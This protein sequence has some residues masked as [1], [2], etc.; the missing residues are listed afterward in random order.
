MKL[1][2]IFTF[3]LALALLVS[4]LGFCVQAYIKGDLDSSGE[5][6]A[7]DAIY[8]LYNV[9]FGDSSYPLSQ[10]CDYDGSGTKDA[11]DAIWLLYNVFFGDEGYPLVENPTTAQEKKYYAPV[12]ENAK[13]EYSSMRSTLRTW[14]EDKLDKGELFSLKLDGA[15]MLSSMKEKISYT[16]NSNGHTA[17]KAVYTSDAHGLKVTLEG[18]LYKDY[19]TVDYVVYVENTSDK[20]SGLISDF[21]ALDSD[22]AL[23]KNGSYTLNTLTGSTA[24]K[25]DFDPVTKTLSSSYQTFA[26]IGGRS[27]DGAWPY[28]D[29]LGDG[30]GLMLAIGWSGQWEGSFKELTDGVSMRARQQNLSTVLLA[31]ESI[32]SPRIVLTYFEGDAE[33]GHNVFRKLQVEH[34]SP[35][36]TEDGYFIAPISIN[37]WGGNQAKYINDVV[38]IY[39]DKGVVFDAVWLDAGWYGDYADAGYGK[40]TASSNWSNMLGVWTVNKNIF[41]S[42]SMSDISGNI[43]AA[44][45]KLMLWYMIEDG[46]ASYSDRL[47]L[48]RDSYYTKTAPGSTN[49]LVLDLSRDDVL[50]D[51]IALFSDKIEN[52]GMDWIRVDFWER[53]LVCWTAKDSDRSAGEAGSAGKRVGITEN[54]HIVNLY[55]L[56]DTLYAKYPQFSLDNCCSGGRRID[57]EMTKRGIALWRTDYTSSDN[58]TMQYHTQNLARWIPFS[59]VGVV[60]ANE[61]HM[62]SIYAAAAGLSTSVSDTTTNLN[63]MLK[64]STELDT[65]R[66]YWYGTYHQLLPATNDTTSWQSY[67]LLRTDLKSAL[68]V[69]IRRPNAAANSVTIKLTGLDKTGW[70]VVHDITHGEDG[71]YDSIKSGSELMNTGLTVSLNKTQSAVFEIISMY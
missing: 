48:G 47:T 22:F 33:Y 67:E 20:T 68:V 16:Q 3:V 63:T 2:K 26:P 17:V 7:D 40:N 9:F 27:S 15:D 11:N 30:C 62:R 45:A 1:R 8:L 58:E 28:F 4:S 41:P 18:V 55:K 56:W 64:F 46:R 29:L 57:I 14:F 35:K 37:F 54:K 70:Y 34:Y 65:A 44:G 36:N 50:E 5:K 42:G 13:S 51:V 10:T 66:K 23:K 38:K 32:R 43:H 12:Y 71:N 31:G 25:T 24:V 19:P 61:Y 60:N 52:E 6:N 21:Y 69:V 59:T 39:K 49:H 53:P